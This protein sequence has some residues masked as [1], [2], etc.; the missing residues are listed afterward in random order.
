VK[1]GIISDGKYGDRAYEIIK[2]RF[3]T[4]WI[5]IDIP[6]LTRVVDQFELHIPLCN[7]Y[8]SYVRHPDVVLELLDRKIPTILGISFGPGFQRQA[9]KMNPQTLAPITMCSVEDNTGIKEFDTY[10]KFFGKPVIEAEL[11]GDVIVSARV[12]REAPCGSTRGAVNDIIGKRITKDLLNYFGLRICHYCRAPRFGRTCNKEFSGVLHIR[13][14]IQSLLDS[15][16][17]TETKHILETSLKEIEK[18]YEER[19][20]NLLSSSIP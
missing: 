14:L 19:K 5:L 2:N 10:A 9:S 12:L 1:I 17:N 18:I 7:L 15:K 8:I 6:P 11:K 20:K 3:P 13:Q 16:I 4:E